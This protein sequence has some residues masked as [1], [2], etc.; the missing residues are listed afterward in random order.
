VAA[1]VTFSGLAAGYVGVYRVDIVVP[2][3][4]LKATA[5]FFLSIGGTAANAVSLLVK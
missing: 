2:D 5:S 3:A 4:A 1:A